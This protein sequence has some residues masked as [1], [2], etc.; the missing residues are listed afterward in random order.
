[1]STELFFVTN[2]LNQLLLSCN[3]N[4]EHDFE[5]VA[6]KFLVMLEVTSPE[7]AAAAE[8]NKIL[9]TFAIVVKVCLQN[10]ELHPKVT[11]VL[12]KHYNK[13]VRKFGPYFSTA[14]IHILI[15][16]VA[17]LCK[18]GIESIL[19]S[20]EVDATNNSSRFKCLIFFQQK[21]A[22]TILT[23]ACTVV[24]KLAMESIQL[25]ICSF[26]VF[27]WFR[28]TSTVNTTRK[29]FMEIIGKVKL[30]SDWRGMNIDQNLEK[31]IILSQSL[32]SNYFNE[33]DWVIFYK[34]GVQLILEDFMETME[35]GLQNYNIENF[36]FC[37]DMYIEQC[38]AF[39]HL[40]NNFVD[41][42]L[43]LSSIYSIS[44][45]VAK[46]MLVYSNAA[47]LVSIF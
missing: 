20:F 39:V 14:S 18:D 33:R 28:E 4:L 23:F 7:L 10:G 41:E 40:S 27:K 21:L 45:R 15:E 2:E 46:S 22:V 13:L 36:M 1:M 30:H 17:M 24:E 37:I 35:S 47:I 34:C 9:D 38:T 42:D 26:G 3:E 5:V 29:L 31:L 12:W 19:H 44:S 32:T 16:A 25:L 6:E 43:Y 11:A 8:F